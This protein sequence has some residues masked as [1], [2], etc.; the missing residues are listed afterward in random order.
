MPVNSSAGPAVA[1]TTTIDFG[2]LGRRLLD[3]ERKVLKEYG[4]L[5]LRAEIKDRWQGWDYNDR[6]K[7]AP[8]NVSLKGWKKR[9]ET[10]EGRA[11]LIII[12]DAVDWRTKRHKYAAYVHRSGDATPEVEYIAED[13][14]TSVYPDMVRDLTEAVKRNLTAPKRKRTLRARGGGSVKTLEVG[15]F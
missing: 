5:V 4:D 13:L 14:R 10:T 9:I 15:G 2:D 6:P 3:D 11:V 8:I 7:S 1:V 12:N